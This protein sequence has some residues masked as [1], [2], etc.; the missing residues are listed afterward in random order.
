MF[1]EWATKGKPTLLGLTTGAVAGLVAVTPASGFAGPMGA[2]ALGV[3][4]GVVCFFFC[5][6]VKSALGYDDSLDVFGVH[7]IGGIIGAL[8]TGLLVNPAPRRHRRRRLCDRGR[9]RR[10]PPTTWPRR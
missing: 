9:A 1:A 2:L 5:T 10:W 4:T 3:V 6:A 7:C 8:G